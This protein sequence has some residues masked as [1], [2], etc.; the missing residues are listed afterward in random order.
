MMNGAIFFVCSTSFFCMFFRSHFRSVVKATTVSKRIQE[1][2]TEEEPAVAK[3]R[4]VC[5]ISRKEHSLFF[6][7]D[8][9]N[10]VVNPQLDSGSVQRSCGKLQ[11]NRNPSQDKPSQGSGGKLHRGNLCE[12]SG[13]CE[14]LQRNIE[15]QLEKTR[16]V[17]K[18]HIVHYRYFE[19]S[20]HVTS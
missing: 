8:A 9:S 15:I 11:R 14:K 6:V 13:T 1:R 20:L 19:K 2:N 4:S 12:R 5:L 7:P 10:A 16:L 18:S 3:P 17:C